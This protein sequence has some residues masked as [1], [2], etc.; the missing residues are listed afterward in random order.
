MWLSLPA[1]LEFSADGVDSDA[2]G[3]GDDADEL[4]VQENVER[5][6]RRSDIVRHSDKRVCQTR[7]PII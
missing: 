7:L 4:G 2:N 3:I 1:M 6:P 5:A